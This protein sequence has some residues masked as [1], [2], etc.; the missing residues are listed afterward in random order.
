M[1]AGSHHYQQKEDETGGEE[2][3]K[4]Q[5]PILPFSVSGLQLCS[6]LGNP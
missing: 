6:R 4:G 1:T 2:V 3:L 5:I